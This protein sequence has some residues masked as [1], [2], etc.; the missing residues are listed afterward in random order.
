MTGSSCNVATGQCQ[1]YAWGPVETKAEDNSSLQLGYYNQITQ[2]RACCAM[3]VASLTAMQ[4]PQFTVFIKNNVLF[5]HFDV[6]FTNLQ[7]GNLN[8]TYLSTCHWD[9]KA[10]PYCP[11]FT[12]Q[13]IAT[14]A[15]V[16]NFSQLIPAGAIIAVQLNW[17]CDLD[18]STTDC[19]PTWTFN[20]LDAAS[21]VCLRMFLSV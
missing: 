15:R 7:N 9:P 10:Q 14:A 17:I 16:Q 5:P 8:S 19:V 13:S 2:V 18:V 3:P 1:I 11:I 12:M 4:T 20:R 21:S 6:E